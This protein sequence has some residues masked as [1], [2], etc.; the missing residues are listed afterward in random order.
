MATF[1]PIYN[2]RPVTTPRVIADET[3]V[4][5]EHEAN[6]VWLHEAPLDSASLTIEWNNGGTWTAMT[7]TTSPT[8]AAGQ[9]YVTYFGVGTSSV[10]FNAAD[11]AKTIRVDY[12]GLGSAVPAHVFTDLYTKK[13]DVD[14]SLPF[15]GTVTFAA[16]GTLPKQVISHA[17]VTSLARTLFDANGPFWTVNAYWDGS[18]WQRDDITKSSLAFSAHIGNSQ[19]EFRTAIAGS[20]NIAFATPL[21]ITAAGAVDTSNLWVGGTQVITN[22]RVIQSISFMGIGGAAAGSVGLWLTPTGL[23]GS[24]TIHGVLSAPVGGIGATARIVGVTGAPAT[25]A[26]SFTS[27]QVISLWAN[28]PTKG[29]GST[30]TTAYGLLVEDI[31]TGATNY[32]VYTGSA[33]SRFGGRVSI[34]GQDSTI[35]AFYLNAIPT[36]TGTNQ[37]GVFADPVFSSTATAFGTAVLGRVNTAAGSFTMATAVNFYCANPT[38]GVG[39]VITTVYGLFIETLTAGTNNYSIW[40]GTAPSQ[41]GGTVTISGALNVAGVSGLTGGV[42]VANNTPIQFNNS[43]AG[44]NIARHFASMSTADVIQIANDGHASSFGGSV[45]A[46][47]ITSVETANAHIRAKAGTGTAFSR[48][49]FADDVGDDAFLDYDHGRRGFKLTLQAGGGFGVGSSKSIANGG[50]QS[51]RDYIGGGNQ[52]LGILIVHYGGGQ[53]ALIEITGGNLT[54]N[55]I[56]GNTGVFSTTLNTA[57]RV[58]IAFDPNYVSPGVGSYVIQNNSGST[59]SFSVEMLGLSI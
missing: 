29:A 21:K 55:L 35:A 24:T 7:P 40:T 37:T 39:S 6:K 18:A 48:F 16:T 34:G 36:L 50:K 27:A 30:I 47:G 32:S 33:P 4:V 3:H 9:F 28:N 52:G 59:N 49:V 23:T 38:K 20:G 13:A 41:F 57:S 2:A 19:F 10:L 54:A 12:S 53:S 15:T 31:T 25:A 26:A 11:N 14:G 58:N 5:G 46:V 44:G 17:G 42:V 45:T 8:P 43:P 51:I 1:T 56:Y 22:A